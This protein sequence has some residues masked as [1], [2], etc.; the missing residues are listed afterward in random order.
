MRPLVTN[1]PRD[2]RVYIPAK[3]TVSGLPIFLVIRVL[4]YSTGTQK[5]RKITLMTVCKKPDFY[6]AESFYTI[7]K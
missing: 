5:V 2:L 6:T 7:K 3:F 4:S 1:F